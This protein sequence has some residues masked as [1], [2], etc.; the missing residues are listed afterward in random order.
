MPRAPLPRGDSYTLEIPAFQLGNRL[1]CNA[2]GL[3]WDK[4][5]FEPVDQLREL[6]DPKNPVKKSGDQTLYR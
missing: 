6:L 4:I 5:K 1:S 3:Y 2:H